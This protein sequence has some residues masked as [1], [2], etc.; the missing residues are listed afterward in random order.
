ML[1]DARE[2]SHHLILELN[3]RQENIGF[4]YRGDVKIFDL[5]LCKGL[6]SRLKSK[7][8]VG[9]LLTPRTGSIPYMAP[10]V[11]LMKPYDC[12]C[13]VFSF[14]VL[15]WEML[16]LKTAFKGYSRLDYLNRVV[17]RR[18]RPVAYRRWPALTRSVI[19]EAWENDP[20]RRP[21]M[22]RVALLL[23][24]DVNEM[25]SGSKPGIRA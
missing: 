5:G 24:G 21:S 20:M 6:S 9:Y 17:K 18:E 8:G 12:N 23:H 22:K 13:D 16:S 3:N 1:G 4:D 7:E 14:A 25:T 2:V 10:E 15:L 11:V 19:K